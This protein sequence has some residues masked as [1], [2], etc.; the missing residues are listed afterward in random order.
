M[1][2]SSLDRMDSGRLFQ[3]TGLYSL[4]F[5]LLTPFWSTLLLGE[6]ETPIATTFW[7]PRY[8]LKSDRLIALLVRR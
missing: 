1:F 7:S 8:E 2:L 6:Y 4:K 3:T 5:D